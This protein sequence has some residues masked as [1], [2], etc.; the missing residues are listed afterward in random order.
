MLQVNRV[1]SKKLSPT[2]LKDSC[3]FWG[4]PRVGGLACGEPAEPNC[5]ASP[6]T[7]HAPRV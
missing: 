2:S 3:C 5:R 7:G 1:P 4:A 6:H